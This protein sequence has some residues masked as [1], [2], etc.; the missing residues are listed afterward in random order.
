MAGGVV[1]RSETG[2]SPQTGHSPRRPAAIYRADP[3]AGRGATAHEMS[4]ARLSSR[5]YNLNKGMCAMEKLG[6]TGRAA[7]VRGWLG[8]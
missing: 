6:P 2:H 8:E 4:R 1:A 3:H 7:P 5:L